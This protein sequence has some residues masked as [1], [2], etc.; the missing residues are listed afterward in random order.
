MI[1][2][3]KLKIK[4]LK[5]MLEWMND[6][7]IINNFRFDKSKTT[8]ENVKNFIENS[9]NDQLNLHYAIVN[10]FDEYLGTISLKKID[11]TDFNAE[12]AIV[13][14]EKA[15][16]KDIAKDATNALL[17]IAF[18]EIGLQKVYLNVLS[19]NIRAIK[20]YEKMLFKYEGEFKNHIFNNGKF[21]NI[22]WYSMLR[23]DWN[24]K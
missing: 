6:P 18:N 13:L 10:E 21:M 14:R 4:D 12:Y 7:N 5:Y 24:G 23:E 19:D 20:F 8:E 22:K 11:M 17:N 15:I 16:G 2:L 9:Q 1:S 3:R